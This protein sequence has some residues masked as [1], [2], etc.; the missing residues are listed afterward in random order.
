MPTPYEHWLNS[1]WRPVVAWC[2]IVI[3]LFDFVVAPVFFSIL[4]WNLNQTIVQWTPLTLQGAG[5]IHM[6]FGAIIG[7]TAWGRTREKINQQ[8]E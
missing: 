8:G 5:L 7:I 2:Y 3:C 1:T 4:Q 6:A